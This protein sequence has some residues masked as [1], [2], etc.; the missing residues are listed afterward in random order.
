MSI[1]LKKRVN[2]VFAKLDLLLTISFSKILRRCLLQIYTVC[3]YARSD[4]TQTAHT[5][6]LN[7]C[8]FGKARNRSAALNGFRVCQHMLQIVA[9]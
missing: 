3:R 4:V 8:S 6:R 9:L 2:A 7:C 5:A 1:V